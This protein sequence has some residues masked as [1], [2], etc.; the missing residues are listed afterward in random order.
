MAGEYVVVDYEKRDRYK[1][2]IGK[3]LLSDQDIN[4][5][6]IKAD[7]AWYYKKYQREQSAEDQ[8]LYA[9]A[10]FDAREARRWLR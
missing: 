3:V 1:R 7:L 2:I 6:Q 5:K 8:Q 4:L 10:G 9:D